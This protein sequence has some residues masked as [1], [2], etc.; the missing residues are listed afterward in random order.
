M[1]IVYQLLCTLNTFTDYPPRRTSVQIVHYQF[2]V[3][4]RL[5]G[6]GELDT[7]VYRI[8]YLPKFR[9]GFGCFK[10]KRVAV[11]PFTVFLEITVFLERIT[12]TVELAPLAYRDIEIAWMREIQC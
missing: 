6:I 2:E 11:I 9:I 5:G 8:A 4:F 7:V 10:D 3:F 12:L 1:V